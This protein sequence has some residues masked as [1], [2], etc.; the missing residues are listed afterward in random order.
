VRAAIIGCGPTG[1]SRSGAHS[2]SYAHAR[3]MRAAEVELVAA[4]SRR[5]KNV[6]DFLAEF[7]GLRGYQDYR[8]M[9][10]E[11]RP[12]F[13][14]VCAF[15]PDREAMVAA[16][17]DAGAKVLWIE[18]P[19]AISMGAAHRMLDAA[20]AHGARLFVNFQRR[21][22]EPFE[23]VKAA[24]AQQRIGNLIG[25]QISQPGNEI[26]N[27]CPHLIDAALNAM[28]VPFDRQPVRV[29]GAVEWSGSLYQG[30]PA[31][32][33]LAGTV[34]FSDGTRMVVEAGEHQAQRVPT[35]RFDGEHGFVEL[36]LS[37]LDS[38]RGIAR[39]C[40]KGSL[41]V[42][43]TEENFHHGTTDKNLY[44]DRALK[45]ILHAIKTGEPSRLDAATVL[46]GLEILLAL[47]ESA[48]QRKMLSLPLK[49]Q[50]TSFVR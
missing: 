34:H 25:I 6:S 23:W 21:F 8:K 47:F 20:E 7:P 39:G 45:D 3:A 27:F 33:Q 9:L 19:F 41:E 31:E 17:L 28:N 4:A 46:P 13:V 15:P 16:A 37:P 29:F 49:Q 32:S 22:G 1:P 5:E 12:E 26:I 48:N 30:V 10:A 2:I 36:R 38:E 35:I 43:E 40:F 42:L 11:E 14:S 24:V 18:K 44:V 50:E